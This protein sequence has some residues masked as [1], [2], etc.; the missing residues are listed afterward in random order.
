MSL[1]SDDIVQLDTVVEPVAFLR[2]ALAATNV[3]KLE[4]LLKRLPIVPEKD[5]Y[6]DVENPTAGWKPGQLH[7]IP[8]GRDSGNA[9]RVRLAVRPENP[10]AERAINSMEALIELMRLRELQAKPSAPAPRS[11]RDAVQRYFGIP[12]L[13][14]LTKLPRNHELRG[15]AREL[16][17]QILLTVDFD[18]VER[19]F[20]VQIRD[21][22]MGQVPRRMHRTLLSLGASD[23]GD[24]AYLIGVFGQGGSSAYMASPYSWCVSRRDPTAGDAGDSGMGWTAVKHIYPGGRRDDYFAYLAAA[25]DGQVPSLP[26][27]AA[28]AVGFKPGTLFSHLRYDFSGGGGSA[29]SRT[30]FPALNHVLYNPV[31]PMVTTIGGTEAPLWGNAYR[32]A[33]ATANDKTA[34]DKMLPAAAV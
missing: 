21:F 27:G 31:L 15:R 16:A 9:G 7:W 11:P 33:D 30:L 24:K 28:D 14:E 20:T 34:K 22:G 10:L 1:P 18:K 3:A 29:I 2:E 8:L 26:A 17:N 32:L 5:F 4:R 25:P 13:P 23:K 12:S 6:Y 19:E